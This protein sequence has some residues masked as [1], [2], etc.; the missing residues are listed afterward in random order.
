[1]DEDK[2]STS[3]DELSCSYYIQRSMALLQRATIEANKDKEGTSSQSTTNRSNPSQSP[4]VRQAVTSSSQSTTNR[5]NPGQSPFVRQLDL[6]S[7][8]EFRR[9]FPGLSKP[10]SG[11]EMQ[12]KFLP[13]R[14]KPYERFVPKKAKPASPWSHNFVCLAGTNSPTT[15]NAEDLTELNLAG[16]GKKR[17]VFTDKNGDHEHVRYIL[18]EHYP[19]LVL[20]NF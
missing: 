14:S 19:K 17:V 8:M 18:E 9:Q 10:K 20:F 12:K 6:P 2:G 11:K 5:S 1:M 13:K 16:L 15:P 4:F 7:M 3:K